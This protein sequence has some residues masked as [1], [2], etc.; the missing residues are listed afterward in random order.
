MLYKRAG[1]THTLDRKLEGYRIVSYRMYISP[2]AARQITRTRDAPF[3][4]S[5]SWGQNT[6]MQHPSASPPRD[7]SEAPRK[8][9][10]SSFSTRPRACSGTSRRPEQ[11]LAFAHTRTPA[12]PLSRHSRVVA[13]RHEPICSRNSPRSHPLDASASALPVAGAP[14][15]SRRSSPTPSHMRPTS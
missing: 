8:T 5:T 11:A 2:P 7:Q 13:A 9:D 15:G 3:A 1:Y 10:K 12:H 4:R 6:L 14:R